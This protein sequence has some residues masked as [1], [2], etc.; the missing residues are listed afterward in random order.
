MVK[1]K[2]FFNYFKTNRNFQNGVFTII[3]GGILNFLMGAVYSIS[4][5][6]VYEISYIKAKGGSIDIYHLT[7]Y[8]PLENFFQCISSFISGSIYKKIGLHLT[9]LIGIIILLFGYLLMYLSASLFLDLTS[10]ILSG[11]GTGI[12]LF[13]STANAIEWF[14][15]KNGLII[16]IMESMISF[17]SFFFCLL[18]EKIINENGNESNNIDNLYNYEIGKKFKDFMIILIIIII[19]GSILSFI[20]MKDKKS[21]MEKYYKFHKEIDNINKNTQKNKNEINIDNDKEKNKKDLIEENKNNNIKE[22]NNKIEELIDNKL[23][24]EI[25]QKIQNNNNINKLDETVMKTLENNQNGVIQVQ[26]KNNNNNNN[27]N[28]ESVK[29]KEKNNQKRLRQL[30]TSPNKSLLLNSFFS[31][32]LKI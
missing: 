21:E 26:N 28:I 11:I 3:G 32:F 22:N 1:L 13:P 10:V 30:A 31:Y 20:L 4:T 19:V 25:N 2:K 23:N 15:N 18:G 16:G 7:F 27:K 9:N 5:L 17:G 6:A 14:T 12:I 29:S 24:E 8:Y